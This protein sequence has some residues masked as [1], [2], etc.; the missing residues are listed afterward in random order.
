MSGLEQSARSHALGSLRV[1][2]SG[3]QQA[4]A[5]LGE[6]G[7]RGTGGRWWDG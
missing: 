3:H 6:D 1:D 2:R 7:F 5:G 4:V